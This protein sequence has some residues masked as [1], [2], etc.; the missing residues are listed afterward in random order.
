[1]KIRP[2]LFLTTLLSLLLATHL[3][4]DPVAVWRFGEAR[5]GEVTDQSGMG[6]H[7]QYNLEPTFVEGYQGGQ[8][9]EF[10]GED[11]FLMA[12]DNESLV[13]TDALTVDAWVW[14]DPEDPFENVQSIVDKAGERYR[15]FVGH[16]AVIGLGLKDDTGDLRG[17]VSP[18]D[19][20]LGEWIRVTA[21]FDRP[22]LA[23]YLDGQRV[24]RSRWDHTI[25][26]GGDLF[27]GSKRG[28]TD[29]FHGRIDTIAI[30]NYARPPQPDDYEIL[31]QMQP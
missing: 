16:S 6:N 7:L 27:I 29:F 25:G 24:S 19:P 10:P 5:D 14:V 17:G 26:R 28:R 20:L 11:F 22:Q 13:M 2:L 4:A 15:L 3:V 21:T 12:L 9:M 30:Y 18:D 23:Y 8:A 31:Q 1:M